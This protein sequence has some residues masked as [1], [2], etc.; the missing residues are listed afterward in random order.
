MTA[1][2]VDKVLRDTMIETG[3]LDLPTFFNAVRHNEIKT[4]QHR[5]QGVDM[6]TMGGPNV[7][8]EHGQYPIHV[9]AAEGHTKMV[10]LII[11]MQGDVNQMTHNEHR[12]A[13]HYAVINKSHD[14]IRYLVDVGAKTDIK[15]VFHRTPRMYAVDEEMMRIVFEV[16]FDRNDMQALDICDKGA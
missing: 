11:E 10:R 5:M 12:T 15:D 6:Q 14:A 1:P 9:A 8:D 2:I 4:V 7:W 16:R 13:L 3:V